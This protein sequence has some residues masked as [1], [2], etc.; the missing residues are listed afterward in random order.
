[1]SLNTILVA[2]HLLGLVFGLGGVAATDMISAYAMHF[3][4]EM[5]PKAVGVFKIISFMV[6]IGIFLLVVS[7]AGLWYTSRELYGANL[8]SWQFYLKLALTALA[9]INGLFLN[10][11]VTPAFEGAVALPDFQKT[12]EFRKAM[13]L[14]FLSGGLS[15]VCWWGAFALG[16]YVFRIMG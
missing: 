14:G 11:V 9:I 10:V 5:L 15:F 13:I 12:K 8:S 4:P 6:W 3:K 7:G 2:A 16:I 1:M